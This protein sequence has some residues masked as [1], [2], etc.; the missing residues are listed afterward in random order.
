M[1]FFGDDRCVGRIFFGYVSLA[2]RELVMMFVE[3][4]G[5]DPQT[6]A[7]DFHSFVK[8]LRRGPAAN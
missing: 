7:K 3:G 2:Q 6:H 1:F 5:V 8:G 4:I